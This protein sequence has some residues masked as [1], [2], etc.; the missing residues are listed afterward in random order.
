MAEYFFYVGVNSAAQFPASNH[1]KTNNDKKRK[2][3]ATPMV[4]ST[5]VRIA[6]CPHCAGAHRLNLFDQFKYLYANQRVEV[7]KKT[8]LLSLSRRTPS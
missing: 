7:E 2:P 1:P 5:T 8:M 4:F 6:S 3:I